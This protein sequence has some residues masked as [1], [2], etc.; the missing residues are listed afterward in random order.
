MMLA[1]KFDWEGYRWCVVTAD[2]DGTT[3]SQK[4]LDRVGEN[5]LH[6]IRMIFDREDAPDKK[7]AVASNKGGRRNTTS[8]KAKKMLPQ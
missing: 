4:T 6:M 2:V 8:E 5:N 7:R 1:S 3:Q